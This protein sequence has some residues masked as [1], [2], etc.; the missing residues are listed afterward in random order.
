MAKL[1]QVVSGSSIAL[2]IALGLG[3]GHAGA[4]TPAASTATTDGDAAKDEEVVITGTF[5]RGT[6]EDTAIPVESTSLKELQNLGS[7]SAMDLVKNMTEVS[8]T[9]GE[10]NRFNAYPIGVQTVNL[11]GVGSQRTVVLF[12]GRRFQ[13]QYSAT[14]GRFNNIAQVPQA[15][16]GRI[17]VLKEGGAIAYGADAIGGVI[18]YITRH[19]FD[20]LQVEGSARNISDQDPNYSMDLLW[21][22]QGDAGNVM[23]SM[24]YDHVSELPLR[25]RDWGIR[26]VWENPSLLAWSAAGQPGAYQFQVN[27][28]GTIATIAPSSGNTIAKYGNY[29]G[30]GSYAALSPS[31]QVGFRQ[32]SGSGSM[33][34]PFCTELG[35]FEGWSAA[36][37]T[38]AAPAC[39]LHI[40]DTERLA[41]ETDSYRAYG[42][43]NFNVTDD[44]KFHAEGLYYG[45]RAP[46]IGVSPSDSFAAAPLVNP[47]GSLTP[48][49]QTSGAA[50]SKAFYVPGYAP[51]VRQLLSDMRNADGSYTFGD[52]SITTTQAYNILNNS[53]WD[54]TTGG[55]SGTRVSL[56]QGLWRLFGAGGNPLT[57][58]TDFQ[59]NNNNL[60]R[61]TGGLSGQLPEI[62][63]S[64][65]HWDATMTYNRF[66]YRVETRDMLVDRVQQA[67]A[68]FGGEGCD[69]QPA[70]TATVE[71]AATG[72]TKRTIADAGVGACKFL[73]P[74]SSAIAANPFTGQVNP[75]YNPT[76]ANDPALLQWLYVPIF[77]ERSYDYVIAD[78]KFDGD[79]KLELPGGPISVAFG[80]QYRESHENFRI[81][82]YSD[83]NQNPCA[84]VG[85]TTCSVADRQGPL[86]FGRNSGV[87]GTTSMP[88]IRD[89]PVWAA[90]GEVN[91]PIFDRLIVNLAGR[92]EKFLSDQAPVDNHVFVKSG[93]I[94]WKA[95]D[96]LSFRAFGSDSF[97]NIDP[98]ADDGPVITQTSANIG[99]YGVGG[100]GSNIL[101]R[102]YD[103]TGVQPETGFNYNVGALFRMGNFRT[104]LDYYHIR[105]G[106][107]AQTVL[108][109]SILGALTA[110]NTNIGSNTLI[111]CANYASLSSTQA[112]LGGNPSVVPSTTTFSC[113]NGTS[114]LIDL[115]GTGTQ[116][117]EINYLGGV[118]QTNGGE[119]VTDGIE[120]GASIGFDDVVGGRLDLSVDVTKVLDYHLSDFNLLG[121]LIAPGY[122]GVGFFNESSGRNL[123]PIAE[124]KTSTSL[125][126]RHG[127]HNFNWTTRW[128]STITQ[129]NPIFS[130]SSSSGTNVNIGLAGGL[131]A[132]GATCTT[133][134]LSADLGQTP[135]VTGGLGPG[136]ATWLGGTVGTIGVQGFCA[137]ENTAVLGGQ[138]VKGVLNHDIAYRLSLPWQT[139]FTLTIQ[140]VLDS[141]PEFARDGPSYDPETGSP[142][143][144][145]IRV[146]LRK[147]F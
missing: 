10:T 53:T 31:A 114:R 3:A 77:L 30:P 83:R 26:P 32:I 147:K 61:V 139:D 35:G 86:F 2:A 27:N 136:T 99:T 109:T 15:A 94:L 51:A 128:N 100:A 43:V 79:T 81:D 85:V 91:I 28:S 130:A 19:D 14:T 8:A 90:F 141:E 46:H 129:D 126:Y 116:L 54:P 17:D 12:N 89:Y 33:R 93:S 73:N 42:E 68:G 70:S 146:G 88:V 65:F 92:Y 76:L 96:N 63:G 56:I 122:D 66:L 67:L 34:D 132:T 120:G 48:T 60:F 72:A 105:I 16:I 4:Q 36:S 87:L 13:D 22:A 47:L 111:N 38:T 20:G 95:T 49:T 6:P 135:N 82:Q 97:S 24:S 23:L 115:F 39:L 75:G 108:T 57:G 134:T 1:G 106:G 84:T 104:N 69:M 123:Q 98:P 107:I 64:R 55:V 118:G 37:A 25:E 71:A 142:L 40:S 124:W 74:F 50:L 18:N 137:G 45:F 133:G 62:F 29:N 127:R 117:P 11:R 80:G 59:T 9:I 58:D 78:L 7:P 21:G 110:G 112:I 145:T 44:V 113:V 102:N 119:L 138:K 144:R 143:G 52:P 41:Q 5:I 125:N 140:N 121:A 131:S 101:T 103:N